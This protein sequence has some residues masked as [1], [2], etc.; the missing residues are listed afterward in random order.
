MHNIYFYQTSIGKIGIEACDSAITNLYFP[1]ESSVTDAVEKET[2][3]LK[4]TGRQLQSYLV[5]ERQKFSLPLSPTG[6]AYMQ[7]VW[8]SLCAIPYGQTRSYQEIARRLGNPKAAR[9]VGLA[10]N[11]NPIPILIPCHRVIGATGKLVGY[12]GG[13]SVKEHLLALERKYGIF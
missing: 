5:G 10:N 13:L 7:R 8:D 12:R 9:A 4:E 11:K 2:D 3:L 6:S 1:G